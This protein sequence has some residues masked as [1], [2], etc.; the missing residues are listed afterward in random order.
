MNDAHDNE[1]DDKK[2]LKR[3]GESGVVNIHT[4]RSIQHVDIRLYFNLNGD[5]EDL[6][7]DIRQVLRDA[8]IPL[9]SDMVSAFELVGDGFGRLV[10]DDRPLV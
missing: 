4:D 9:L 6:L 7:A 1:Q 10:P 2:M 8:Q 3:H 5:H